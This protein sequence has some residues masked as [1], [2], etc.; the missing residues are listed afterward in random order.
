MP[1]VVD[2]QMGG[3]LDSKLASYLEMYT[4]IDIL[5]S[6][7]FIH[8]LKLYLANVGRLIAST[9]VMLPLTQATAA[10]VIS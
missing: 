8:L 10:N 9:Q 1:F 2:L 6:Q 5:L 4:Y 7:P 3:S